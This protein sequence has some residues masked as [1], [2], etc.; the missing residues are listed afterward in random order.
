MHIFLTTMKSIYYMLPLLS[1]LAACQ[2][3]GI[4]DQANLSR[5]IF[6]FEAKGASA[7]ECSLTGQLE[8]GKAT[9]STVTAGGCSACR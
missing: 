6:D 1:L 3:V 2:P 7:S 9:S 8:T 5:S 4:T